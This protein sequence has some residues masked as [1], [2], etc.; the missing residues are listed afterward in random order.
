V[1][2]RFGCGLDSRIYGIQNSGED[3]SLKEAKFEEKTG[4]WRIALRWTVRKHT[5]EMGGART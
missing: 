3:F 2:I 1:R 5:V 4:D